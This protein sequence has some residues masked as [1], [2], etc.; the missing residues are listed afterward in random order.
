MMRTV[1]YTKVS[2]DVVKKNRAFYKSHVKKRFVM[3]LAYKG[4][5]NNVLT[6][7]ELKAAYKGHLPEDLDI[8]HMMPLSGT[9][10]EYVNSFN[11]L[12]VLHKETHK[13]IN[14][15]VFQ[16]QLKPIV[17][18]P[19]GSSIT[20]DIPIYPSVDVKGIQEKRKLNVK[21]FKKF[22]TVRIEDSR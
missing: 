1:V 6:K 4:F 18:M 19:Y 7:Q 11:N 9:D 21:M 8:H 22:L 2:P 17:N 20:I 10:L 14:R 13:D 3:W 12:C 15:N 5:F 16:P